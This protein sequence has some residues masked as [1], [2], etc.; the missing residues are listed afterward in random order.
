MEVS[1]FLFEKLGVSRIVICK[2]A[3]QLVFRV[4]ISGNRE[5]IKREKSKQNATNTVPKRAHATS[6]TAHELAFVH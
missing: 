3:L 4:V 2:E 6:R 5:E 1:S